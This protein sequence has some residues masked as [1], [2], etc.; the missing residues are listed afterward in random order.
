MKQYTSHQSRVGI[1]VSAKSFEEAAKA[2]ALRA[3]SLELAILLLDVPSLGQISGNPHSIARVLH[4]ELVRLWTTTQPQATVTNVPLA[5]RVPSG[6]RQDLSEA[7]M[8]LQAGQYADC[9]SKCCTTLER[10][11]SEM[12]CFLLKAACG[13]EW[14]NQSESFSRSPWDQ[15]TGAMVRETLRNPRFK[16][17]VIRKAMARHNYPVTEQN[18][19]VGDDEAAFIRKIQELRN[20]SVHPKHWSPERQD[21]LASWAMTSQLL[22]QICH[23]SRMPYR[24]WISSK[25]EEG[26]SATDQYGQHLTLV[27][28]DLQIAVPNMFFVIPEGALFPNDNHYLRAKAL[29][30]Y[31]VI[32][33]KCRAES[34]IRPAS[35][36]SRVRCERCSHEFACSRDLALNISPSAG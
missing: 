26:F 21:A 7:W 20:P 12:A 6:A 34:P 13:S 33:P 17:E 25:A 18:K 3:P 5:G 11:L 24:C 29:L 1:I 16:E 22:E 31:G 32:C 14:L 23:P 28:Q 2:V 35:T 36:P 10:Y 19:V 4:D 15:W 8:D 9:C 27:T 30:P